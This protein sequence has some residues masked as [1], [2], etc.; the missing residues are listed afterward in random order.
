VA[1]YLIT[2][3]GTRCATPTARP[4]C[5]SGWPS[6]ATARA[7]SDPGTHP[8]R[9]GPGAGHHHRVFLIYTF[10]AHLLPGILAVQN[11]YHLAALL[12]PGLHRCGHPR[13]DHGGV[14]DLHHP[15]H[16][17]RGLPAG[18]EG[19]R[20]FRQLRLRRGGPRARRPGQGG[21]LR[22]RPDGHDQRH[23]GGQRG[24]HRLAH[25]PADEEGR[26]PQEDRRRDRGRG[27]DRRADHAADHGRGRL[28]H[29]RDHRHPLPPR[30]PSLRSS[31]RCSISR[32]STSWSISR[33]RSSACAAC[34]RTSCRSS[35]TDGAPGLPV[36]ADH[37]PDRGAFRGLLGDP[38]AGTLATAACRRGQLADTVADGA[39][40]HRAGLRTGRDH[41][42]PDHRGLRL[43]RDHRGRHLADR[44]S[45]RASPPAAGP[46]RNQPASGAVLRHVHRDP[47]RH[48]H[49]DDGGLRGGGLG[50]GAGPR[51]AGHPDADGAFLRLLLRRGLGDHAARGAGQLRGRRHIGRQPDGD[52]GRLVQDRHRGLH[53]A[54]HVLL[55]RRGMARRT[56][57]LSISAIWSTAAPTARAWSRI[58]AGCRPATRAWWFWPAITMS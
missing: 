20:L 27:L 32:R 8:P 29:G 15:L 23:L 2:I 1:I 42:D 28:H 17:L 30:S 50:R 37:H 34:A 38:G 18:L 7:R 48:G 5:P 36:P 35:R 41:V 46:R 4:S 51:A 21:D 43:R 53:R 49:A 12:R 55:Q 26:L 22:L 31:R 56:H 52:L 14:L 44:A 10:T 39:A 45:A 11:A 40:R 13:A 19:R 58:C 54:L 6:L 47:A 24:G 16:H 9:G 57:R 33:P 25:D 3:Y